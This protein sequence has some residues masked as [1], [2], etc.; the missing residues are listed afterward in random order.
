MFSVLVGGPC[1]GLK[2]DNSQYIV[3]GCVAADLIA[4]VALLIVA[5]LASQ[6]I[7]YFSNLDSTA[8]FYVSIA[9][10]AEIGPALTFIATV[11]MGVAA[12]KCSKIEIK[13]KE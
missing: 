13:Y 4:G 7:S 6:H 3:F 2:T 8:I 11:L 9:A 10:T 12:E 1:S 5:V